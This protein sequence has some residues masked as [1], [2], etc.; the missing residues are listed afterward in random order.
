M[1]RKTVAPILHHLF[2]LSWSHGRVL[3]QLGLLLPFSTNVGDDGYWLRYVGSCEGREQNRNGSLS[4]LWRS[5]G[6]YQSLSRAQHSSAFQLP[7][8][9]VQLFLTKLFQTSEAFH[10][11]E[12]PIRGVRD[13][14]IV[15]WT[16]Y[17]NL[18]IFLSD[19]DDRKLAVIILLVRSC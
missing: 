10:F 2:I 3:L 14:D 16:Y 5:N 6:K 8:P 9:A 19:F 15:C 11:L 1:K 4:F 17:G 13:L 7:L 12:N 18:S